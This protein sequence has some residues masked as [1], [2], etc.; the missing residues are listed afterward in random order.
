[1]PE[2]DNNNSF[3]LFYELEKK[4]EKAPDFTGTLTDEHGKQWRIAAWE[5]ASKNGKNFLSGKVSEVQRNTPTW[6][7]TRE[8][9]KKPDVVLEDITD[10]DILSQIPF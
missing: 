10:D 7:E 9:Y 5:R 3:I 8:R 2:Y 6:D 1:M 4:S